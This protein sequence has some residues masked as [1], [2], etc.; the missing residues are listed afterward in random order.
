MPNLSSIPIRNNKETIS[1][2]QM[3]DNPTGS[4]SAYFYSRKRIKTQLDSEF[5]YVLQRYRRF[6]SCTPIL[7]PD[8]R[9]LLKMKVP[10]T[11]Y[12]HN[13]ILY[14]V[15]IEIDANKKLRPTLRNARF[16]SN[17]MDFVF[18]YSYVFYH[19]DLMINRYADLL[20]QKC[21][22]QAPVIRNPVQSR[23]YCKVIYFAVQYILHGAILSDSYLRRHS[24]KA[25]PGIDYKIRNQITS[26]DKLIEL[27]AHANDLRVKNHRKPVDQTR[28][29]E[30]ERAKQ[31][32]IRKQKEEKKSDLAGSKGRISAAKYK[33]IIGR[34]R[35]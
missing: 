8:G 25:V 5:I 17:N 21:I 29:T 19:S 26:V 2:R 27:Y 12:K 34:N 1:L 9:I 11:D 10:S 13:K 6:F 33:R 31:E 3:V 35:A 16:W 14:D 15:L 4:G 28:R 20:P 24:I 18:T 30:R 7:W 32:Y 22:T 23:G